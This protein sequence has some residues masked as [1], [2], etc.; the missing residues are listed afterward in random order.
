MRSSSISQPKLFHELQP[1]GGVLAR[2]SAGN[3]SSRSGVDPVSTDPGSQP[4]WTRQSA[5]TAPCIQLAHVAFRM[6]CGQ[7]PRVGVAPQ[8]PDR[9]SFLRN[10]YV[11][12]STR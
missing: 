5:S 7:T 3:G 8:G 12:A 9:L 4:A 11:D 1:I 2:P 6:A 10:L